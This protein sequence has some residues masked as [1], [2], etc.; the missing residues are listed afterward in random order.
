MI[1]VLLLLLLLSLFLLIK[2]YISKYT[3]FFIIMMLGLEAAIFVAIIYIA[4]IANYQETRN[5][6]FTLDY[7]L[8]LAFNRIKIP[9]YWLIRI[10]N[11]G[12]A[13][14]I[15]MT[16]M[17]V[18]FFIGRKVTNKDII[19]IVILLLLP[20]FY[21]WFYD[22]HTG[23]MLFILIHSCKT[24]DAKNALSLLIKC[25]DMFNYLW[26]V[27]YLF[28]PFFFLVSLYKNTVIQLKKTQIA[29][30][31]LCL[32][33]LNSLC[34]V[35]FIIGPFKEVYFYS[36]DL[37]LLGI[38][39]QLRVPQYYYTMLPIVLLIMILI[40][41][42]VL[43]KYKGVDNVDFFRQRILN[44]NTKGLNKNLRNTFHSFKNILFTLN[45]MTKQLQ[46]DENLESKLNIIKDMEQMTQKSMEGIEKMLDSLDAVRVVSTQF[47]I[48]DVID[49][50][51][52]KLG[53][54]SRN[55][56]VIKE[57]KYPNV[58]VYGDD[59][60]VGEAIYNILINAVEAI[61]KAGT[62]K[63]KIIIEVLAEHEWVAIKITDNG[64]G[65]KKQDINNI[66]KNFYTTKSRLNNWG[67][68]LSYA[69]NVVRKHLG[70][71]TAESKPDKY[72]TF[73][74]LLPIYKS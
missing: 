54:R 24:Q 20:A 4:R 73:Q 32:T 12:T 69:Y 29:A 68:G 51:V 41:I 38:K 58:E 59:Y 72:T 1:Y 46:I 17:F 67:I 11:I 64:T 19:K 26:T 27:A 70:Y 56:E 33:I 39:E 13:T 60:H 63:G 30:I 35:L 42:F 40:I 18:Y 15:A 74:I 45:I 14:Y 36:S 71:I 48:I 66:F 50:A 49:L 8:F 65:I 43:V 6:L 28:I 55:I 61:E 22:P 16:P 57:Y 3:W 9:Y 31:G 7:Q 23:Y 25:L 37:F 10:M 53:T 21:L 47:K 52:D 5:V 44:R 2:N 34:I 62:E